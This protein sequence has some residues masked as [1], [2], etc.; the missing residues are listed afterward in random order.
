MTAKF[1]LLIY[2]THAALMLGVL[3]PLITRRYPTRIDSLLTPRWLALSALI[4][5]VVMLALAEPLRHPFEDFI[6]SYYNGGQTFLASRAQVETLYRNGV[7]GFV[8]IPIV[9]AQFAPFA[10]LPKHAAAWLYLG[11]GLLVVFAAFRLLAT[12]AQLQFRERCILAVLMLGNGP[13]MNSLKEGNT[14]HFALYALALALLWMHKS[15]SAPAGA[16][17]G[18]VTVLKLPLALFAIWGVLRARWRFASAMVGVLAFTVLASVSEFGLGAQLVWYRHFVAAASKQPL[19]AFNVQC[20]PAA[21]LRVT[22]ARQVMCSWDPVTVAPWSRIAAT[23][24]SAALLAGFAGLVLW[25]HRR[26][27]EKDTTLRHQRLSL[28]FSMVCLLA[29]CTTPL[30][31]SHY[32][33]WALLPIAHA[34]SPNGALSGPSKALKVA[35][36]VAIGMVSLPVAWPWCT[37]RGWLAL[38]YSLCVSHYLFGA[39]LMLGLLASEY[40]AL[41][42]VR[43]PQRPEMATS[44]G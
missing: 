19:G 20:F 2:F 44:V 34:L 37:P 8:N 22:R 39:L 31:W 29:C 32:Y 16:V 40:A 3:I 25:S 4:M 42:R 18:L 23:L 30:A 43:V 5:G 13:L 10:L 14:S 12:G 35:W 28:E 26:T 15:R 17:L 36:I 11:L 41:A 21:L 27:A 1:S 6:E 9:A 38:P 33:C 24:C 7:N